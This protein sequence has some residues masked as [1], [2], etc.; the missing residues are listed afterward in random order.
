MRR[1]YNFKAGESREQ[2]KNRHARKRA[3]ATTKAYTRIQKNTKNP[4]QVGSEQAKWSKKNEATR[5]RRLKKV[6]DARKKSFSVENLTK[7]LK[8]TAKEFDSK[9][10]APK[11]KS[12]GGKEARNTSKKTKA[13]G[14]AV[15]KR[16]VAV[17]GAAGAAAL[18][19]G[20]Y[21][22]MKRRKKKKE[23]E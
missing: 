20:A 11:A 3:K 6:A 10:P 14:G 17:A 4:N 2:Q 22:L 1:I 18:G 7:D 19:V 16:G 13:V 9:T 21:K 8:N 12:Y 15:S 5:S 23:N